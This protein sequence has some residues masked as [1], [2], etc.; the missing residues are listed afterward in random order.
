M[1]GPLRDGPNHGRSTWASS[2]HTYFKIEVLFLKKFLNLFCF[3]CT[4]GLLPLHKAK[5]QNIAGSKNFFAFFWA[6]CT[7]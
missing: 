2:L 5:W 6:F 4:L 7:I 3:A 1:D